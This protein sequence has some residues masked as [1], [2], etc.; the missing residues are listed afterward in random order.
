MS[1]VLPRWLSP[2]E[3]AAY[4]TCRPDALPRYVKR[5]KI[6]PPSY[7][8]GPRTPKY[9]REALDRAFI[10]KSVYADPDQITEMAVDRIRKASRR[11]EAAR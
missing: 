11:S 9:D 2:S 10:K 3:A 6:P 1:D 7:Q 5:G 8:F 4:L